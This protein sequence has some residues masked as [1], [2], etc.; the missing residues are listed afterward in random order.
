LKPDDCK[1]KS[2]KGYKCSK[3]KRK[4]ELTDTE[5]SKNSTS[6]EV[7]VIVEQLNEYV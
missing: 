1:L 4:P 3:G 7:P 2:R 6:E 5:L